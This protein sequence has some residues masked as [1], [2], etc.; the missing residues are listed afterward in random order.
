MKPYRILLC[1]DQTRTREVYPPKIEEAWR[2]SY[3][4]ENPVSVKAF[5]DIFLSGEG[6]GESP[7]RIGD[8][9]GRYDLVLL[10]IVW[11]DNGKDIARGVELAKLL[12]ESLPE[13]PILI[14]S[15][16]VTPAD[17]EV[18]IPLKINGF[19]SKGSDSLPALVGQVYRV[20]NDNMSSKPGFPIYQSMRRVLS[21]S[22]GGITAWQKEIVVSV[23]SEMWKHDHPYQKWQGFWGK[24]QNELSKYGL[25]NATRNLSKF[26]ATREL[27]M[28][29]VH[30][31]F[32]GHLEH[33]LHVY[34]TGYVISHS[35]PEFKDY[36][37]K[38]ARKVSRESSLDTDTAW[39]YFQISWLLAATLHDVGYPIEMLP[40]IARQVKEVQEFFPFAK[41]TSTI[42]YLKPDIEASLSPESFSA[43]RGAYMGI[44]VKLYEPEAVDVF[45][46]NI[47]FFVNGE[48][49]FN[50]GIA[51]GVKLLSLCTE[52]AKE[53]GLP[54]AFAEWIS[55][56]MG[57]HSLKRVGHKYGVKLSM[58]QD[59]LSFLL[60]LS[61]EMQIWNRTR[62]DEIETTSFFKATKLKAFDIKQDEKRI[63]LDLEYE[64]YS[65]SEEAL[66]RSIEKISQSIESDG[67]V[68]NKYLSTNPYKLEIRNTVA[69]SG[70]ELAT[71]S[72]S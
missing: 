30:T 39:N 17:F 20:L 4:L 71:I 50:H 13:V 55:V 7:I 70:T 27:L 34:F 46:K 38:A 26:F 1:D 25:S 51:S 6:F 72:V 35:I 53:H 23:A 43:W 62:P 48:H 21:N 61:D 54:Y 45:E 69:G 44:M 68:L 18:L 31:G 66:E 63:T 32:R 36:V 64:L 15:E 28:L 12:R 47:L 65:L 8:L 56:A 29:A 14:F 22:D 58:E 49:R 57:L 5:S 11:R 9:G 42:P 41:F 3:P 33:V 10:D 67:N 19:V 24:W 40:V 60:F 52:L 37:V 2:T 59:P 16:G